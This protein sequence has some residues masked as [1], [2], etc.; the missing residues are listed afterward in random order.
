M[1]TNHELWHFIT[2]AC[3]VDKR[4]IRAL[5]TLHP[6]FPE[7]SNQLSAGVNCEQFGRSGK[8][9]QGADIWIIYL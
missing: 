6:M 9:A 2:K 7:I 4:Q 8:G 1:Q 5:F 3:P